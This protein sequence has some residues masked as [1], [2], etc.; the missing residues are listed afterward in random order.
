MEKGAPADE[1]GLKA[2]DV[3]TAVDGAPIETAREL[4]RKIAALG[5]GK[6]AEI[7]YLRAGAEKKAKLKLGTLPD[8]KELD[9]DES[10]EG[11]A[12]LSD[13]GIEIAPAGQLRGAGKE[14]VVVVAIDPSGSAAQKG[15]RR[16]DVILEAGGQSVSSR[17]DLTGAIDA[18]RKEGR[19]SV[20]LR[21]K[22]GDGAKF[23][24]VPVKAG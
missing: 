18:A 24:A 13:L 9:Q 2:G 4:A 6:T 12:E 7:T 8:Q 14:G 11:G 23:V 15:L 16:G 3:V 5:P 21:V 10:T 1:A 17:S 20:L 22:S 19:R